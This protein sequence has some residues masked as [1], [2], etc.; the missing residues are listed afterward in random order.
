MGC[1]LQLVL[2][3]PSLSKHQ[4]STWVVNEPQQ[5]DE[6]ENISKYCL[7]IDKTHSMSLYITM[8]QCA[9]HFTI[10]GA[11]TSIQHN[12]WGWIQC[13]RACVYVPVFKWMCYL[14]EELLRFAEECLDWHS[15]DTASV[16]IM[17]SYCDNS[18][19]SLT[20]PSTPL[21]LSSHVWLFDRC[22]FPRGGNPAASWPNSIPWTRLK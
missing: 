13:M 14:D 11:C 16:S 20:L 4:I 22:L 7:Q 15:H 6:L 21:S 3:P 8:V 17:A 2:W 9:G 5:S 12:V 18:V 19:H 1:D 10:N